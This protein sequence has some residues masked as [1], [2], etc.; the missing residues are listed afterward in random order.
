M[1][2]FCLHSIIP[3]ANSATN[4]PTRSARVGV[5]TDVLTHVPA[6]GQTCGHKISESLIPDF[7]SWPA[8]QAEISRGH[9][10]PRHP[11][12]DTVTPAGDCT[13]ATSFSATAECGRTSSRQYS[14]VHCTAH[15][16]CHPSI[17]ACRGESVHS[18]DRFHN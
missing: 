12:N 8:Y 2:P 4:P 13:E 14:Q 15:R 16:C 17:P 5:D 18:Y 7:S 11:W 9:T 10:L 6:E 1:T 3:G